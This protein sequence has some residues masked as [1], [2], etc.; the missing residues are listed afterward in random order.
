MPK[1]QLVELL[2]LHLQEEI[3]SL[4]KNIQKVVFRS[5]LMQMIPKVV[6]IILLLQALQTLVTQM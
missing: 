2:R 1:Q 3:L 5:H 6:Q 4:E